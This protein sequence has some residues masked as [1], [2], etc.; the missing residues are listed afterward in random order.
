MWMDGCFCLF[1]FQYRTQKKVAIADENY[2]ESTELP[3]IQ[4]K[5]FFL[6]FFVCFVEKRVAPL[7]RLKEMWRRWTKNTLD[8]L[9]FQNLKDPRTTAVPIVLASFSG[10]EV[11]LGQWIVQSDGLFEGGSTAAWEHDP[12]LGAA[13]FAGSISLEITQEMRKQGVQRTGFASIVSPKLSDTHGHDL[14]LENHG[15]IHLSVKRGDHRVYVFNLSPV[16]YGENRLLQARF[17]VPK[18]PLTD[19]SPWVT[20]EIPK[21][22]F[23]RTWKGHIDGPAQ[24]FDFQ[25]IDGFGVLMAERK[26]GPFELSIRDIQAVPFS[27]L[28][29]RRYRV[30]PEWED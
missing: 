8:A 20:V 29:E 23:I 4:F 10:P 1:V 12:Q 7:S 30:V 18:Q 27:L 11:N 9:T 24:P 17:Q 25:R 28:S 15:G 3:L 22:S 16:F 26:E 6:Y 21:E 13:R 5:M 2:F 19:A 14:D